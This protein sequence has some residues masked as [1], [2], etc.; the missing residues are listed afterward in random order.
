MKRFEQIQR[1]LKTAFFAVIR[2]DSSEQL[3]EVGWALKEGGCDLIEVTMTT[4]DALSVIDKTVA[5]LGEDVIVGAGSVLDAETARAAILNGAEYVVSPIT[6]LDMIEMAHRYDKPAVPGAYTPTEA[7]DA[8]KAGA[9]FVKIFPASIGGPKYIK[10]IK[11]PMPQL[12]LVPTGGVNLDNILDFLEA[13]AD[14]CGVGSALVKK[15]ALKEG[16]MDEIQRTAAAF[17][18]K[19]E[20]AR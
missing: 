11:A 15:D 10:A 5:E 16:D 19:V 18:E 17:M 12:S 13:G 6:D 9:D 20:S 3:I 4:P 14:A 2:A 7:L 1:M 8:Y